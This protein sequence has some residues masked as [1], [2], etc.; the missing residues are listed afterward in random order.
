LAE[1]D[2]PGTLR[3]GGLEIDIHR[4]EVCVN[5][6]VAP[7]GAR[8]FDILQALAEASGTTVS[9]SDL[10][11]RVWP[12]VVVRDNALEVQISAIRKALGANR[13]LL[14]TISGR[15]YRL[16]GDWRV[17]QG[18]KNAE[19]ASL[20]QR[21]S[22]AALNQD[23]REPGRE[24]IFQSGECEIDLARRELRLR[25]ANVPIGSRAFDILA[26]LVQAAN[27]LVTRDHLLRWVWSGVTA[28]ETA[29][30]VHLSAIRKALGPYR[31]MLQTISGH[32]Y[33]LV[34]PWTV[35]S[36]DRPTMQLPPPGVGGST[37]LP[38]AVND[39]VGRAASLAYLQEACSAY[40]IVTLAGPGGIGK[41]TLAIELAR[42]LSPG[43]RA[44]VWLVELASLADPDLV[45]PA[46]AETIGLQSGGGPISAEGVARAIGHDRLLLLLDNCEHLIGAAAHLAET[47]LRL[48]P[49]A[50][51]LATSRETLR[52]D[53]ECVY[54][55]PPL[56]VPQPRSDQAAAIL[57]TS[58]VQ[59]FLGRSEALQIA[60][61]REGQNLRL[62]ARICRQ[63]D[64]IP[65]AIEFAA[66]RAASLGLSQIASSLEDRFALLTTGRRTALPRHRT[67]RAVLDWSYALLPDAERLLLHR[68]A[69]FPGGFGFEAACAV[70]HDHPLAEV[71]DGIFNLVEKSIVSFD[72]STPDERWRLLETVRAYGLDK[73]ASSGEWHQVARRHAEHF[74]D[75]FASFNLNA[76]LE[77]G[78]DEPLRYAREVD[79]LRAALEWAFSTSGDAV[80][81]G[82]L[83]AAAVNFWLAAS[84]LDECRQWIGKALAELDGTDHDEQEMVLRSGLGLALLFTEGMTS[85]ADA[86]LTRALAIAE[87]RDSVEYR[88]RTIYGFWLFNA[89][90]IELR[91]ALQLGRHYAEIARSGT[92]PSAM[93]IAD[94]MIGTTLTYLGE[95]GEAGS[96]LERMI[97]RYPL[98]QR[99][100]DRARLGI[101][102]PAS[103][104]CHLSLGL[105]SRGLIDA[106]MQAAERS[107]EEARQIG[108]P[109]ALCLALAWPASLQFPAVGAFGTAERHIAAMLEQADRHALDTFHAL[110]V[111]AKGRLLAMRGDP[112]SG[113]AALRR[114]LAQ[115]EAVAYR[116]FHVFF[117]GCLAEALAVA[118]E[119]DEGLT[120]ADTALRHAEQM[121]YMWFLP[122]LFRIRGSIIAR[123]QP[124]DRVA[125]E[126]FLRAL[127]LAHRQHALYWEL[128]AGVSLAEHWQAHARLAEAR[129]LLAPIC[130]RFTEGFAAPIL[131]RAK[132]LLRRIEGRD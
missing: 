14:M 95:Y 57:D 4:R 27:E 66:A 75:F 115:L 24:P 72:R 103:A 111:C 42:T 11:Q 130:Q 118:G 89:R 114:G 62:I 77:S 120:E 25:G 43:F 54:R 99:Y 10:I 119:V 132:A 73:L 67:L 18:L 47:I 52:T 116:L 64:G 98:P 61:L 100:G 40:R 76:S 127:D 6:G 21:N 71:A 68:L 29:I 131:V 28:G 35:Q 59:L 51:I 92:D 121:D 60:S 44:G 58:A 112:R 69:I 31:S 84:L 15:G 8:A 56:D 128:R 80:L 110:A 34:G 88:K 48:A 125:E 94:L 50:V 109:V 74:R 91:K 107:I 97:R 32:G 123:R 12:D 33:R 65:L 104:F 86:S 46:V 20:S 102:P 122:E 79:N 55:V 22:Q 78:V 37:N 2:G 41:T 9:K 81:G 53:G 1:G 70:M 26:V 106:A 90:S 19:P 108:Q 63:L 38:A 3:P 83:A 96:L 13:T 93:H 17:R 49:N 39:L 82:V 5:G 36:S 87:S 85:A 105:F 126:M 117:R 30:D 45:P 129:T 124:D 101:D 16:V 23:R 7:L 113:T